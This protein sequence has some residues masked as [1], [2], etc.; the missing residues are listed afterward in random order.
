MDKDKRQMLFGLGRATTTP[1]QLLEALP[2]EGDAQDARHLAARDFL[3]DPHALDDPE[4]QRAFLQGYWR[5]TR[6]QWRL[7][8]RAALQDLLTPE[9]YQEAPLPHQAQW[10]QPRLFRRALVKNAGSRFLLYLLAVPLPVASTAD[11]RTLAVSLVAIDPH[12]VNATYRTLLDWTVGPVVHL[13]EHLLAALSKQAPELWPDYAPAPTPGPCPG[14]GGTDPDA[15]EA[16]LGAPY[17]TCTTCGVVFPDP[18]AS[19]P[20]VDPDREEA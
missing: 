4:A 5:E 16:D 9:S 3:D 8:C 18:N 20:P 13:E 11:P 19:P 14:C 15:F 6:Q 2:T 7:Y 12:A 10:L 17:L 1:Y